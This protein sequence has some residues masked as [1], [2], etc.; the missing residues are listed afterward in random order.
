MNEDMLREVIGEKTQIYDGAILD[1]QKWSVT[2]AN[3]TPAFREVVLHR[4]ASAIV[5]V[6]DKGN[7]YLVRQYRTPFDRIMLEIPAGKLDHWGED[8]FE[9]AKRELKEET[10]FSA[11]KWT[12]LMDMATT[13]GFCSEL[14]SLYLAENLTVGETNFDDDE[15]LDL[16]SMPL[17]DAVSMIARGEISDGKTAL[18][19]LMA[20]KILNAEEK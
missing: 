7:V 3:G 12:H 8:R 14:I 15:F 4:G 11:E 10:G 1:V 20:D 6:D 5:P 17:K 16:V 19:I 13:P 18:A 2:L 9:C